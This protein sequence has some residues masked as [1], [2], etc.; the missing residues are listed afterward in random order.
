[1]SRP[2]GRRNAANRTTRPRPVHPPD[3]RPVC[4][5]RPPLRRGPPPADAGDMRI[6]DIPAGAV[7]VGIDGSHDSEAAADWA[8]R[9]AAIAH[10]DLVLLCSSGD[11]ST[12]QGVLDV[13]TRLITEQPLPR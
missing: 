10:R 7:V 12:P 6:N 4:T 3:E 11:P 9:H 5:G 13:V 1:M 8:L 2:S